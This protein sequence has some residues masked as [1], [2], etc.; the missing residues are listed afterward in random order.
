MRASSAARASPA[1][2]SAGSTLP[3][4]T[5]SACRITIITVESAVIHNQAANINTTAP[6]S[7][8]IAVSE[9]NQMGARKGRR[10]R[11]ACSFVM[12]T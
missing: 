5:F 3:S 9:N 6:A 12:P 11:R 1:G 8:V 4:C 2:S 7:A 10:C